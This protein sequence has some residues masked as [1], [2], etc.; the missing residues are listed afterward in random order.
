MQV[1]KGYF[2]IAKKHMKMSIWYFIIFMGIVVIMTNMSDDTTVEK[3]ESEKVDIAYFD[4]D[5]SELSEALCSYLEETQNIITIERNDS[6]FKD[7][8]YTHEVEYILIIPEGFENDILSGE[9]DNSLVSYKSPG[10]IY[11]MFVDRKIN[12]FIDI[13]CAYQG[14]GISGD[15]AFEKTLDTLKKQANVM[16]ENGEEK[17]AVP[18]HKKYFTYI[19]YVFPCIML[20]GIAPVLA[21]FNKKEVK[22]RTLCGGVS[23]MKRNVQL[24]CGAIVHGLLIFGM[25]MVVSILMYGKDMDLIQMELYAVNVFVHLLTSLG[26]AFAIGQFSLNENVFSMISNAYS[27][28]SAFLCGVFV[29]REYLSAVVSGIGHAFPAY[30]Y[31]NI[32]EIVY[33]WTGSAEQ[34]QTLFTSLG[35]QLAFAL[36]FVSMGLVIGKKTS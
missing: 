28:G 1:F 23:Y 35:V 20:L 13:F 6:A 24:V 36:A 31:I 2:K 17:L 14:A 12:S 8:M 16:M 10:T 26:L 18:M 19:P 9:I 11:A 22:I 3:F 27:L 4:D 30:W 21:V 5:H 34:M 29:P 33:K 15:Q 25:F 32:T 7:A